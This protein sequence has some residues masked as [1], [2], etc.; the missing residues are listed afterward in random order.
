MRKELFIMISLIALA[1][2]GCTNINSN[3]DVIQKEYKDP[4]DVPVDTLWK[5]ADSLRP[6]TAAPRVGQE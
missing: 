4:F 2:I 6:H 3:D 1:I 5:E